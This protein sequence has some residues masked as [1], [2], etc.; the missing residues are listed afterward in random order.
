M[1]PKGGQC[2]PVSSDPAGEKKLELA[3][4]KT[5]GMR[6]VVRE[7]AQESFTGGKGKKLI[8]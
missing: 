4:G 7:E 5:I 1:P 8:Q 6:Q 2:D 3:R